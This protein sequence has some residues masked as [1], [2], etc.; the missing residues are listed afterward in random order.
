LGLTYGR[1][2]TYNEMA[3][4]CAGTQILIKLGRWALIG[5]SYE[6]ITSHLLQ[7]PPSQF[8]LEDDKI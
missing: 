3:R 2:K 6:P 5:C 8:E 1:I 7:S 4:R